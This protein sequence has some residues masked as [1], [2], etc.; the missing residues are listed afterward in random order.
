MK[1][2]HALGAGPERARGT[3]M[4]EGAGRGLVVGAILPL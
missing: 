4:F 1:R 3:E 2:A